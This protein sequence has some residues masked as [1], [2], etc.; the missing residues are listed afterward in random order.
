MANRQFSSL[1]MKDIAVVDIPVDT[2]AAA[3]RLSKGISFRTISNQDRNDFD[4]QAF[5]DWH[6][7]LV[8]TYPLVHKTLKREI[9]CM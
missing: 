9:S 8:D 3:E 4:E 6:Q 5:R 7:Y 2:K 1:Q